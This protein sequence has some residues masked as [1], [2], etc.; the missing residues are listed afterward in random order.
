MKA[1]N[2]PVLR[3]K[4]MV[5]DPERSEGETK[6]TMGI[7][8]SIFILRLLRFVPSRLTVVAQ[9][10]WLGFTECLRESW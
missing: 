5:S 8:R 3:E 4:V 6:G 7:S 1:W 9:D 2:P 10:D